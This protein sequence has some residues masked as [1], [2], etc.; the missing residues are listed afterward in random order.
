MCFVCMSRSAS[1][2][3]AK[4]NLK[5]VLGLYTDKEFGPEDNK[6]ESSYNKYVYIECL[7]LK[8]HR[9]YVV[10]SLTWLILSMGMNH[11]MS[12]LMNF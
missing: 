4:I 5:I 10:M 12:V 7:C 9:S 3:V 8:C 11:W 2:F 1:K 6:I